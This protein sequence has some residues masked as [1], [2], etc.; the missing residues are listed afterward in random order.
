MKGQIPV[1]DDKGLEHEADVMGAKALQK[2]TLNEPTQLKSFENT[3]P[4]SPVLNSSP[5]Q[6]VPSL[7]RKIDTSE[8]EDSV[9]G[10]DLKLAEDA[11]HSFSVEIPHAF[12]FEGE[13]NETKKKGKVTIGDGED[14]KAFKGFGGEGTI[15]KEGTGWKGQV[16]VSL[17][18]TPEAKTPEVELP[19][20]PIP[21]GIPGLW[22]QIG[23]SAQASA[24]VGLSAN[25]GFE[26]SEKKLPT[27]LSIL[28]GTIEPKASAEATAKLTADLGLP[29]V[30]TIGAGIY[31]TAKAELSSSLN[32]GLDIE[33]GL[34]ATGEVAGGLTGEI[35]ALVEAK[36]LGYNISSY[37]RPLFEKEVA[38]FKKVLD[39]SLNATE[40]VGA[41]RPSKD[42]IQ[43]N[44]NVKGD[45]VDAAA[46]GDPKKIDEAAATP[47][48]EEADKKTGIIGWLRSKF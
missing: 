36:V 40:F 11:V 21:T 10:G 20:P 4:T 44:A 42:S 16:S 2:G 24:S 26:L 35:G 1:N 17:P 14:G 18:E 39:V 29:G 34:Y 38:K 25:V 23:L 19:I 7:Q 30:A 37:K 6:K 43:A 9:I 12:K 45:K 5:S 47:K 27:K 32:M 33:K 8:S 22:V 41:L 48:A 46:S 3:D 28:S 15:E 31:G 13:Y